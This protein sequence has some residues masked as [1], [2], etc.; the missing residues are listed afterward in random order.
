NELT[1][2]G[3]NFCDDVAD[4]PDGA[5]LLFSAHGVSPAVRAQ[6][7]A[8]RF[9]AVIDLTCPL[10]ARVHEAVRR[11]ATSQIVLVGKRTHDEIAGTMGEVPEHTHVVSSV[12]DVERLRLDPAEEIVYVTQTTWSIQDASEIIDAVRRR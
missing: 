1:A 8:R 4:V 9:H 6:A 3:V 7:V 10:V 5:V 2:L 12:E 11:N